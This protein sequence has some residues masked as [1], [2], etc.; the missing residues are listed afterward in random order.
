V[1]HQGQLVQLDQPVLQALLEWQDQV[2]QQVLQG[3]PEHLV[4][5]DRLE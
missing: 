4:L 5:L 1:G 2:V 3:V